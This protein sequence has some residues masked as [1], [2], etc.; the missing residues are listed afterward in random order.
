[1]G[2][3]TSNDPNGAASYRVHRKPFCLPGSHT[4][5]AR[6]G[7][8]GS[9]VVNRGSWVVGCEEEVGG[10]VSVRP[11]PV[12]RPDSGSVRSTRAG[13]AP[14]AH[15]P[16]CIAQPATPNPQRPTRI[17]HPQTHRRPTPPENIGRIG[18]SAALSD[19][20]H[21]RNSP[22]HPW[23]SPMDSSINVVPAISVASVVF[24]VRS[25]CRR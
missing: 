23:T 24:C 6:P 17:S 13:P 19:E 11:T 21:L 16:T 10:G 8:E 25:A 12:D 7:D 2:V 22:P 5:F 14:M 20:L 4:E 3:E 9:W 18:R 1:M 15:R